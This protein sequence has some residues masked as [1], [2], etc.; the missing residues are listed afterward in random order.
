MREVRERI[1]A[2]ATRVGRSPSAI[3]LVVVSKGRSDKAVREV[4]EAGQRDFGENR[5]EELWSRAGKFP[6]DIRWHFVGKL[7][8]R[9]VRR[10]RLMVVMLHSLDRVE[11]ANYWLEGPGRQPPAMLQVN[12]GREPRKLGVL[13]E[14]A[15]RVAEQVTALGLDLRGLS[16]LP[17]RGRRAEDSR[18]W[19]QEL[20]SLRA[21]LATRWE[22]L[23][24]LSMG[25]SE[26]FEVAVEE[27]ATLL[28][29]GRAIF[30]PV[31]EER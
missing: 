9:K 5:A 25:M 20:A 7:Q 29:V 18:P 4:Y 16:T 3:K 12:V 15:E 14:E 26:D 13:P 10:V 19:F 21:R 2:A 30:E 31:T 1:A 8:G 27:G 24:E 11:L 6:D 28:R 17:P 22:R 23:T